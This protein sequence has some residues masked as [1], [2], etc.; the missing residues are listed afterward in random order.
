[1]L[2]PHTIRPVP[3][4]LDLVKSLSFLDLTDR[5]RGVRK[6]DPHQ[7]KEEEDERRRRATGGHLPNSLLFLILI[8]H[9]ITT[10]DNIRKRK[11]KKRTVRSFN[12]V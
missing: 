8:E 6:R 9:S 1:M 4:L 12:Y 11:N 10:N 5:T 7:L 2:S 3:L